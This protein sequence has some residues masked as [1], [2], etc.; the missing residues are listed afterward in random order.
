MSDGVSSQ[1]CMCVRA[2][3]FL[4]RKKN[5]DERRKLNEDV[6]Y[7]NE[8][9]EEEEKENLFRVSLSRMPLMDFLCF[10]TYTWTEEQKT[11]DD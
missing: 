2:C 10:S 1:N 7:A 4:R 8:E 6:N 3:V 11:N 5:F 9:E